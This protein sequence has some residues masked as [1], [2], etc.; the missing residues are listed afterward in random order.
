[1]TR[2]FTSF[3]V[4]LQLFSASV[5]TANTLNCGPFGGTPRSLLQPQALRACTLP[6]K[7]TLNYGQKFKFS[8]LNGKIDSIS[9]LDIDLVYSE[10]LNPRVD[11]TF[12]TNLK[13]RVEINGNSK[14]QS[15]EFTLPD[16]LPKPSCSY[17]LILKPNGSQDSKTWAI[18]FPI[19]V[20]PSSMDVNTLRT[21]DKCKEARKFVFKT[22]KVVKK[23][24]SN[25]QAKK[26]SQ[27]NFAKS[28]MTNPLLTS[29]N[30][31]SS[32]DSPA[33]TRAME[34]KSTGNS[35]ANT[36]VNNN[37]SSG[38]ESSFRVNNL[39]VILTFAAGLLSF[40]AFL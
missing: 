38:S 6:I 11:A 36:N 28:T 32:T 15:M 33:T 3:L 5:I 20:K 26:H 17:F 8:W 18:S 13:R 30:Q 9:H 37:V 7:K 35:N 27:T 22:K 29:S 34:M 19:S 24:S 21:V 1:M 25:N 4:L 31:F 39:H 12:I 14:K 40:V 10:T 23:Q 16:N 2:I